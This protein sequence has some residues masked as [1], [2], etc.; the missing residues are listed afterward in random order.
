MINNIHSNR[1]A[2]AILIGDSSSSVP[3]QNVTIDGNTFTNIT[4]DT[5]GAYGVQLNN[6][7]GSTS[8]SGLLIQNNIIHD[9][10]GTS[11]GGWVHAIGLEANTPG[12]QVLSNTITNLFSPSLANDVIAVWIESNPGFATGLVN[13]NNLDV[14]STKFGI[15][16]HPS[17]PAGPFN[18]TCNWWG[19]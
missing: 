6:G 7:N 1:S 17:L 2:K 9:L 3:S 11:T 8:N 12:F 15:A 5:R 14:G 16:V 13:Q 18:G 19:I 10:T 4:S